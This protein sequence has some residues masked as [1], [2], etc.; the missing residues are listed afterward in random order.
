M[1]DDLKNIYEAAGKS[2][3]FFDSTTPID[4]FRGQ[5]TATHLI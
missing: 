5:K 1:S 4:L 2:D 3:R